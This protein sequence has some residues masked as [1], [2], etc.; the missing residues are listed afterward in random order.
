MTIVMVVPA[1]MV[2]VV[3]DAALLIILIVARQ[4]QI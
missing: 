4:G 1:E 2:F 3:L